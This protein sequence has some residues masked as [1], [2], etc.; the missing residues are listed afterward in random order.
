MKILLSVLFNLYFLLSLSTS[1]DINRISLV[2]KDYVKLRDPWKLQINSIGVSAI[3]YV[4]VTKGSTVLVNYCRKDSKDA[5]KCNHRNDARFVIKEHPPFYVSLDISLEHVE[6]KDSSSYELLTHYG[7][8]GKDTKSFN[9]YILQKPVILSLVSNSGTAMSEGSKMDIACKLSCGLPTSAY[10]LEIFN[11]VLNRWTE[12][13]TSKD[14]VI[15]PGK[16][17]PTIMKRVITNEYF[18]REFT[19]VRCRASNEVGIAEKKLIL[20]VQGKPDF[21]D[22]KGPL[23]VACSVPNPPLSKT[24]K[25]TCTQTKSASWPPVYIE[26]SGYSRKVGLYTTVFEGT[27]SEYSDIDEGTY[28]CSVDDGKIKLCT[29]VI[30]GAFKNIPKVKIMSRVPAH[31]NEVF[32]FACAIPS[33][34]VKKKFVLKGELQSDIWNEGEDRQFDLIHRPSNIFKLK[35]GVECDDMQV[36]CELKTNDVK[37]VS[38]VKIPIFCRLSGG[39]LR[40]DPPRFEEPAPL[41]SKLK[42]VGLSDPE[43]ALTYV[44]ERVLPSYQVYS[45]PGPNL[46]VERNFLTIS[47]GLQYRSVSYRY[48][49]FA[50]KR[51]G[52]KNYASN[53]IE[54]SFHTAACSFK[55]RADIML[56]VYTNMNPHCSLHDSRYNVNETWFELFYKPFI[57]DILLSLPISANHTRVAIV[58]TTD[59]KVRNTEVDKMKSLAIGFNE[60]RQGREYLERLFQNNIYRLNATQPHMTTAQSCELNAFEIAEKHLS[61]FRADVTRIFI[62]SLDL[63]DHHTRKDIFFESIDKTTH[64]YVMKKL[65]KE[66]LSKTDRY[67]GNLIYVVNETL[68]KVNEVWLHYGSYCPSGSCPHLAVANLIGVQFPFLLLPNPSSMFDYSFERQWF[69]T[70]YTFHDSNSK[71]CFIRKD[72]PSL[73]IQRLPTVTRICKASNSKMDPSIIELHTTMANNCV[74]NSIQLA[75]C[76]AMLGKPVGTL[77]ISYFTSSA[78]SSDGW[79][80]ATKDVEENAPPELNGNTYVKAKAKLFVP[81]R[82]TSLKIGCKVVNKWNEDEKNITYRCTEPKLSEPVIQIKPDVITEGEQ[83]SII[84]YTKKWFVGKLCLKLSWGKIIKCKSTDSDAKT[85]KLSIVYKIPSVKENMDGQRYICST[86]NT[87]LNVTENATVVFHVDRAKVSDTTVK[88]ITGPD[89]NDRKKLKTNILVGNWFTV[90]CSSLVGSISRMGSSITLTRYRRGNKDVS[91]TYNGNDCSKDPTARYPK[92]IYNC[93]KDLKNRDNSDSLAINVTIKTAEL[94]QDKDIYQCLARNSISKVEKNI[95]TQVLSKPNI[96]S[97]D[98]VKDDSTILLFCDVACVP[99]LVVKIEIVESSTKLS[100]GTTIP[101]TE[102]KPGV[103]RLRYFFVQPSGKNLLALSRCTNTANF[104]GKKMTVSKNLTIFIKPAIF[105]APKIEPDPANGDHKFI[106]DCKFSDLHLRLASSVLLLKKITFSG[107]RTNLPCMVYTHTYNKLTGIWNMRKASVT[108]DGAHIKFQMDSSV[109]KDAGSYSCQAFYAS[110]DSAWTL[111]GILTKVLMRPAVNGIYFYRDGGGDNQ[112]Q[113]EKTRVLLGC[114]VNIGNKKNAP[115]TKVIFKA[116]NRGVTGVTSK[117]QTLKD[118]NTLR[119]VYVIKPSISY[120]FH[121]SSFSCSASDNSGTISD[122]SRRLYVRFYPIK[123]VIKPD[124]SKLNTDE[125]LTCHAEG[126]PEVVYLWMWKHGKSRIT[127]AGPQLPVS[128]LPRGSLEVTCSVQNDGKPS[129]SLL[130]KDV[131]VDDG[132]VFFMSAWPKQPVLG[133]RLTL[134]C[135]FYT[136]EPSAM[137]EWFR[138][139]EDQSIFVAEWTPFTFYVA[140]NLQGRNITAHLGRKGTQLI[141]KKALLDDSGIYQCRYQDATNRGFLASMGINAKTEKEICIRSSPKCQI[142]V[143][144]SKPCYTEH[145]KVTL[146]TVVKAELDGCYRSKLPGERYF[147]VLQSP[148]DMHKK[149]QIQLFSRVSNVHKNERSEMDIVMGAELDQQRL[150]C[151]V[152]DLDKAEGSEGMMAPFKT[153]SAVV[154]LC[155]RHAVQNVTISSFA[156]KENG[157]TWIRCSAKGNPLPY[158]EMIA[159]GPARWNISSW[160]VKMVQLKVPSAIQGEVLVDCVAKNNVLGIEHTAFSVESV[161]VGRPSASGL[162]KRKLNLSKILFLIS[163]IVFVILCIGIFTYWMLKKTRREAVVPEADESDASDSNDKRRR[164]FLW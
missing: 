52:R 158:M 11:S 45:D 38:R 32:I 19:H 2:F 90:M 5:K 116:R 48:R 43:R 120:T 145:D 63:Y 9:L 36:I 144:P 132:R 129:I 76:T 107:S 15:E 10:S 111:Q 97:F 147:V 113:R 59:S 51:V 73:R 124:R 143:V 79:R 1:K 77:T 23:V 14:I 30:F 28:E 60:S 131:I 98:Y 160:G 112:I 12:F 74:W 86:I 27:K 156:I 47:T 157:T 78:D 142:E 126:Y 26:N 17:K 136:K 114:L 95:T 64:S 37:K 66:I 25:L 72:M 87:P 102:I 42:A 139:E 110:G 35:V 70:K 101:L 152:A 44:W 56:G 61:K 65:S 140:P 29:R 146:M 127:S 137:V 39:T 13:R 149:D 91:F 121:N 164:R 84:C 104:L 41:M 58:P 55:P 20:K 94:I 100:P 99:K 88:Y 69:P 150:F 161:Q 49:C 115:E 163:G 67:F 123:Q 138:R 154:D 71:K 96:I 46:L 153:P 109:V 135:P 93:N 106:V 68:S 125:V 21:L 31:K 81:K 54:I 148:K 117:T 7:K 40:F 33:V 159:R 8:T 24:A 130:K 75:T 50:Y 85:G 162:Q 108:V 89:Y 83:A 16:F 82:R 105:P 133:E 151:A 128:K 119:I 134:E 57:S 103:C 6:A 62:Y 34:Y 141:F 122:F 53:V 80:I 118:G 22:S 155:V 18:V 4:K 3:N 92:I